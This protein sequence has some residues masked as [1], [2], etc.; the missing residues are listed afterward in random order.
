MLSRKLFRPYFC[1]ALVAVLAL[2]C[3][4][5]SVYLSLSALTAESGIKNV[6]NKD[7]LS[8]N[9]LYAWYYT[10]ASFNPAKAKESALKAL[11]DGGLSA[12]SASLSLIFTGLDSGDFSL[13]YDACK[14]VIDGSPDGYEAAFAASA[15]FMYYDNHVS[16]KHWGETLDWIEAKIA[17]S[18]SGEISMPYETR[19]LLLNVKSR[20]AA[21]TGDFKAAQEAAAK[22]GVV[23]SWLASDGIENST[24]YDLHAVKFPFD[25]GAPVP[26]SFEINGAKVKVYEIDDENP[27]IDSYSA[28]VGL[29]F[30]ATFVDIPVPT[31]IVIAVHSANDLLVYVDAKLAFKHS[32]WSLFDSTLTNARVKLPAGK[33]RIL[34]KDGSGAIG[35]LSKVYITDLNGLPVKTFASF[36]AQPQSFPGNDR[37]EMGDALL[38]LE[39]KLES[40][41]LISP[42]D[43]LLLTMA[44]NLASGF[45]SRQH[46]ARLLMERAVK[47]APNFVSAKNMYAYAYLKD[48]TIPYEYAKTFA[49][50]IFKDNYQASGGGEFFSAIEK[51]YDA[52]DNHN[53]ESALEI[54]KK[55][56]ETFPESSQILKAEGELYQNELWA[57]ER[58]TL[59]EKMKELEPNNPTAVYNLMVEREKRFRFREADE[60]YQQYEKIARDSF[61]LEQRLAAKGEIDKAL[62]ILRRQ[63]EKKPKDIT[64]KKSEI[65]YLIQLFRFDEALGRLEW[66]C[67]NTGGEK[68]CAD[69]KAKI[70]LYSASPDAFEEILLKKLAE[71]PDDL[72]L[73]R[74]VYTLLGREEFSAFAT[75]GLALI[76]E[77]NDEG[78]SYDTGKV[79]VLDE[80][81]VEFLPDGSSIER[82]HIITKLLTAEAAQ[83]KTQINPPSG[84][85]YQLRAITPAGEFRYPHA[86]AGKGTLAFSR[87]DVG[88]FIEEDYVSY[89][90]AGAGGVVDMRFYF[91]SANMHTYRSHLR[92]S[93]PQNGAVK[94][95][96]KDK[97]EETLKG[98]KP[99]EKNEGGSVVYE[100]KYSD[101]KGFSPESFMPFD[102]E[103]N[104]NAHMFTPESWEKT[105]AAKWSNFN[106]NAR[107]SF[108]IANFLSKALYGEG[109]A[110]TFAEMD[111]N[112]FIAKQKFVTPSDQEGFLASLYLKACAE[113]KDGNATSSEAAIAYHTKKNGR[114]NFFRAL[115]DLLG[116]KSHFVFVVPSIYKPG[117]LE[118]DKYSYLMGFLMMIQPTGADKLMYFDGASK[119]SLPNVF[120]P[121]YAGGKGLVLTD[122]MEKSPRFV[123]IPNPAID[124]E[125][126]HTATV[127]LTLD[128][129]GNLIGE[130]EES[131][132]G[133]QSNSF[134]DQFSNTSPE[135]AK[136]RFEQA[137]NSVY[138]GAKLE[139]IS[140]GELADPRK[141]AVFSYRFSVKKFAKKN[142]NALQMDFPFFPTRL[143]RTYI[144]SMSR[145]F[146]LIVSHFY[147][148]DVVTLKLPA[149]YKLLKGP[150]G[151]Q[152]NEGDFGRFHYILQDE[153]GVVTLKRGVSLK[154]GQIEP[155]D[156]VKFM[157][158][159]QF[160]EKIEG[161]PWVVGK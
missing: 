1:A 143:G 20:I 120:N 19:W 125:T 84:V 150:V 12:R 14:R 38:P 111:V 144:K 24:R 102:F 99:V 104:P 152:K 85:V 73:R 114:L 118:E 89:R 87:V 153:N 161:Q 2:S 56:K 75:D 103:V 43:P 123:V 131:V 149:G 151:E 40:A 154:A 158:F 6:E 49:G 130:G 141:P 13:F 142:G 77:F 8:E 9:A 62:E 16:S 29:T 128:E 68:Y 124:P 156:Y 48:L 42:D 80:Y 110:L 81:I 115:T 54:I 23:T 147:S 148:S 139:S 155:A 32:G 86:V 71:K 45:Y 140:I 132:I 28:E 134:R 135:I 64:L 52:M 21:K 137:L 41:L 117:D 136:K 119:Y 31:E 17:K 101:V 157:I 63:M 74:K 88:D 46:A 79:N 133:F 126:E 53:K 51:Y 39:K 109:G 4:P 26:Q 58:L 98:T 96:F 47:V 83:E 108:E 57:G 113:I 72:D 106:G 15:L 37:V 127:S 44:S 65:N 22:L 25:D 10:M 78:K 159:L 59:I 100:W 122:P 112:R 67:K 92:V 160:G 82:T 27:V 91:N 94:V 36:A 11:Q 5:K 18:E 145:V 33:H 34:I 7:G 105:A 107:P 146:P 116:F 35:G 30:K 50:K 93:I 95:V 97:G 76:K 70:S 69:V 90:K 129:E 55:I 60:L 66:F 121:S 138:R 3:A 61:T